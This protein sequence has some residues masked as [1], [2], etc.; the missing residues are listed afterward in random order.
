MRITKK[1]LI[2][3][4]T[5][6]KKQIESLQKENAELKAKIQFYEKLPQDVCNQIGSGIQWWVGQLIGQGQK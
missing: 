5:E 1:Q 4:N 2:S 6:L 3:E